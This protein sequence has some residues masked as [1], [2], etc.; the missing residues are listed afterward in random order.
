MKTSWLLLFALL[1]TFLFSC[2][3]DEKEE[4]NTPIEQP[5]VEISIYPT[6]EGVPMELNATYQTQEGYRI[7]FSKFNF[8]VS[9]FKD[10]DHQLFPAAVYKKEDHD[11]RLFKGEGDFS[12]FNDV[13]ALLGVPPTENH[14]DP[15]ARP[16]TDPLNIMNTGD[17]H[18]GWNPGYIFLMIE[19]RADTTNTGEGPFNMNFLYHV[20]FEQFLMP[21]TFNDLNWIKQNNLL[22]EL[23]IGIDM[24]K[25]FNGLE[26]VDIKQERSSHTN[27][28]EE[29]LSEK[30]I[31]N[32][33]DAIYLLD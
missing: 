27:P 25:V 31:N 28:G 23:R 20:G 8:I 2:K 3:D 15:S 33:I 1:F 4:E 6:Y 16:S 19:G 7:Q 26:T 10:G 14:K 29:P 12:K 18:W 21:L 9:E 11:H 17:M 32:F 24:E 13:T 22:H 30:V 5:Q